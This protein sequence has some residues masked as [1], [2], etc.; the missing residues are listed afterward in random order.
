MLDKTGIEALRSEEGMESFSAYSL[1]MILSATS[2]I[3]LSAFRI[4]I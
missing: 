1:L 2:F 4:D 3:G